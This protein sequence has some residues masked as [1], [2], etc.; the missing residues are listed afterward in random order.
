VWVHLPSAWV[1]F[2]SVWVHFP[3][4]WVHFPSAWVHFP[5]A[6]PSSAHSQVH[7]PKCTCLKLTFH[8]AHPPV[9]IPN[10]TFPSGH[11]Q[12]HIPKCTLPK[13]TFPKCRFPK[14]TVTQNRCADQTGGLTLL[15]PPGV[16]FHSSQS[17]QYPNY[18]QPRAVDSPNSES[19]KQLP[20]RQ[21][22]M[23]H[24]SVV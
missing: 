1:H 8:S 22:C 4:A 16:G 9:H 12:V 18:Q 3:S 13:C 24:S 7:I 5:S 14:C 23:F 11:S 15:S 2:P 19:E 21:T 6:H 10:C 20:T 17:A